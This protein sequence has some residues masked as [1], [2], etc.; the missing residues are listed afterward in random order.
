MNADEGCRWE[1]DPR[2]ARLRCGLLHAPLQRIPDVTR[3]REDEIV[4]GPASQKK[5]PAHVRYGSI[6]TLLAE[7]TR[8]FMSAMPPIATKAVSRSE[9]SLCANSDLA[10]CSKRHRYSINSSARSKNDS[11][12][13]RPSALAA[14]RLITNSYLVGFCTGSSPAFAPLRMRSIYTAACRY[15]SAGS[16]P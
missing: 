6:S 7:T 15:C 9:T 16:W 10:H 5:R 11:G 1:G 2:T 3:S 8:P 14:F 13:V 12:I 4:Q